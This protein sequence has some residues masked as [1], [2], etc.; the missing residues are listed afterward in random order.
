MNEKTV[1]VSLDRY[2]AL[3]AKEA[4]YEVIKCFAEADKGAYGFTKETSDGICKI[5]GIKKDE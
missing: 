1:L 3:I 4:E 5:L 2:D